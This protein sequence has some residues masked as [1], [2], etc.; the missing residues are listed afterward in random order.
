MR[1][2][3]LWLG[4]GGEGAERHPAWR[5]GAVGGWITLTKK[6]SFKFSADV[7]SDHDH[8]GEKLLGQVPRVVGELAG[9]GGFGGIDD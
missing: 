7:E 5:S 8:F 2:K 1:S 9:G 6:P 4:I 3:V